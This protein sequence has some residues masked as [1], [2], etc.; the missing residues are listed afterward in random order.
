MAPV[1]IF[2]ALTQDQNTLRLLCAKS[3]VAPIKKISLLR[4][5]LCGAV[6]LA[7]LGRNVL[8]RLTVQTHKVYYWSDSTIVLSWITR[9]PTQWKTFVAN[10]VAEIQRETKEVLWYHVKSEDNPADLL[11][12]GVNPDKLKDKKIW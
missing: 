10:R 9:E 6:L 1:Y 3:R 2:V 12:R 7:K 5:E 8:Q 11:S 4:L